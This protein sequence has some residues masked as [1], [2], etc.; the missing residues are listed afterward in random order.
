ME[1]LAGV[2]GGTPKTKALESD[3]K[4][5]HSKIGQL[6]LENDFS[7]VVHTKAGLLSAK[8]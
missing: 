4:I 8:T 2:F 6:T 3:L 1:S 7:G 5:L